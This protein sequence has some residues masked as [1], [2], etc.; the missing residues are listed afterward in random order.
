MKYIIIIFFLISTNV[1]TQNAEFNANIN[2][3]NETLEGGFEDL[4]ER[5][6]AMTWIINGKELSYGSKTVFIKPN[7]FKLDTIIFKKNAS[8]KSDTILCNIS[9]SVKYNIGFNT[10]CG[11]FYVS[12]V[13]IPKKR[14]KKE[15]S[16]VN[17]KITNNEPHK[18]YI[19]I[20][21][22]AGILIEK[23]NT[24][25]RLFHTC[26]S[27]MSSNIYEVSISEVEMSKDYDESFQLLCLFTNDNKE[28]SHANNYR[29]IKEK[30]SFLYLPLNDNA[31]TVVLDLE[32]NN[33]KL[34]SQY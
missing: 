10:C 5:A 9:K 3:L 24:V 4:R 29:K 18:K 11:D 21:E 16:I 19:G 30:V 25:Y 34:K 27:A 6:L 1:F 26:A 31:L 23:E 22:N 20:I 33:W 7:R 15:K 14:L 8:S 28:V 32:T 2:T 13:Y 17:F 12:D